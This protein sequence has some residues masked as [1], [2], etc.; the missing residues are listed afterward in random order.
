MTLNQF[1]GKF[2]ERAEAIGHE[3]RIKRL[4]SEGQ[5]ASSLFCSDD[6]AI[7]VGEKDRV[8]YCQV[9]CGMQDDKMALGLCAYATA[10][11]IMTGRN[12]EVRN[13]WLKRLGLF[14]GKLAKAGKKGMH[15][16]ARDYDLSIVPH[17][18]GDNLM[19]WFIK[20]VITPAN[21]L[22]GVKNENIH[23]IAG[24]KPDHNG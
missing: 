4:M 5:R 11:D 17:N 1:V 12:V 24:G 22:L 18:P 16:M 10:L 14:D 2:N 13:G 8:T 6:V 9:I 7:V 3:V 15:T 21:M 19:S 23:D 20:F